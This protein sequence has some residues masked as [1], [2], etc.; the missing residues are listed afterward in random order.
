MAHRWS[1]REFPDAPPE[2]E[3]VLRNG[4]ELSPDRRTPSVDAFARR[5]AS[6]SAQAKESPCRSAFPGPARSRELLEAVVRAAAGV[7]EAAS[8]SV[9]LLDESSHELV[10]QAAWGAGADEIVGVRLAALTGVAGAVV[11]AAEGQAVPDCAKD[12]HF[13]AQSQP[14]RA[15]CRTRCSSCR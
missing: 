5:W 2:L 4:L 1:F 11:A 15:T 6:R 7:F 14:T 13:A 10:Y 3:Q 8:A 9:A 12:E